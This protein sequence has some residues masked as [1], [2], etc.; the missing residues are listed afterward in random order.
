[1]FYKMKFINKQF[2]PFISWL[3]I[4]IIGKTSVVK[5][6]DHE[7]VKDLKE[8]K[9]SFIYAFWHN[10]LLYLVYSHR[11]QNIYVMTSQSKDGEYIS[12]TIHKFGFK[13]VRGSSTRGGNR[14]FVEMLGKL[15][16]NMVVA[17]T[18]DGPRGPANKVQPG[19]IYLSQK[20]G[21][22]IVPLTYSV[23]RK[24]HLPSWDKFLVPFPF[25][26]GVVITGAPMYIGAYDDFAKKTC[27]LEKAINKIT[28]EADKLVEK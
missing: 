27:E 24:K 26:K 22:P 18:P 8:K 15:K 14:A 25:N 20:S 16:R 4:N 9:E 23:K 6:I 19:V 3:I 10:R 1:M 5:I 12:R 11:R 2:I 17:I 7:K 21:R 28:Q 13:T